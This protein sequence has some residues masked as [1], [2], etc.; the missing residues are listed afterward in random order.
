MRLAVDADAL[1]VEVT[2]D[3]AGLAA[4]GL[5]PGVGLSSMRERAAEMGGSL[6]GDGRVRTAVRGCSPG[7]RWREGS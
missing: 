4:V 1:T 6:R 7:C 5:V 3:G 2:D